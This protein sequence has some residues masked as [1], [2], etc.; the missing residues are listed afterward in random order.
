MEP[1]HTGQCSEGACPAAQA[2]VTS[3]GSE[4]KYG[5]CRIN[6]MDYHLHLRVGFRILYPGARDF[7]LF[8]IGAQNE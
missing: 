4:C 5:I 2:Q 6:S 1:G 7:I 8:Q 3:Q